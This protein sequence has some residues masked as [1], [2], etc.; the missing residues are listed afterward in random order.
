MTMF[1]HDYKNYP[2]LTNTELQ[3]M[4]FTSPHE[5]IT[6]NFFATVVKVHDGDTVTLRVDFRDFD[7]PLRLLDINA[8]ELNENG[9][10]V[11]QAWLSNQILDRKV[12][13]HIDPNQRVGKYGRLLGFIFHNGMNLNET[14][15]INGYATPFDAR[16][17]GKLPNINKMF[18]EVAI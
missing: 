2:E 6:S 16:N 13:I 4:G 14:I 3:T 15:V 8:P 7:F 5:Q 17:D 18:K 1:E 12:E 11:S 9:G 10:H